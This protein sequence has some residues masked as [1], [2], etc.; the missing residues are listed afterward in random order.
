MDHMAAGA[1]KNLAQCTYT[2]ETRNWTFEK[3][4]IL[5]KEQHNILGS[6]KEHGYTGIEQRSKVR[7]LSKGINTTSINSVKIYI[8]SD[9]ILRQDFD[10]RLLL[11]IAESSTNN[12]SGNKSVIFPPEDRYYDP[13]EWYAL[14][15]KDK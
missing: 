15:K 1:D 9:E 2:G 6:L 13:N 7:Y 11:G 12:A 10:N 5:R 4:A 8:M 14:I 3:Y